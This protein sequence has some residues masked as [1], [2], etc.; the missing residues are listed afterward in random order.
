MRRVASTRFRRARAVLADFAESLVH[1]S[2]ARWC[3]AI[4]PPSKFYQKVDKFQLSHFRGR[5]KVARTPLPNQKYRTCITLRLIHDRNDAR[6][7]NKR[8]SWELYGCNY[9][10]ARARRQL[11]GFINMLTWNG[12]WL[13]SRF[14]D[15]SFVE[16]TISWMIEDDELTSI[17]SKRLSSTSRS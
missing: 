12:A 3:P 8:D 16:N 9:R 5:W 13:P 7:F 1:S 11:V 14:F 4:F 2:R 17:R 6:A 15:L 10:L